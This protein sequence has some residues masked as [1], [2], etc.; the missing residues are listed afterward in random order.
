MKRR[1]VVKVGTKVL[2]DN[3]GVLDE[4]ALNRIVLQIAHLKLDGH[5]VTLV[6]SGAMGAGK[7]IF[8]TTKPLTGL[9][10]KQLYSAVGQAHL[11][12]TYSR[13]FAEHS[14]FCAQVLATKE[15]FRDRSHFFNM[16]NCLETLLHD[17]VVPIVNENDVVALGELAFTDNDELAGLVASMLNADLLLILSS[18]DGVNDFSG[19]VVGEITN[20]DYDMLSS[21]VTSDKSEAGRGGMATKFEVAKR[22]AK[23]GIEV[24]I[25]NGTKDNTVEAIVGGERLGTRFVPGKRLTHAQRRLA[26]SDALVMGR[27]YINECAVDIMNDDKVA[28]LLPVGAIKLEGDFEKGDVI[29]IR[30]PVGKLLGYGI[31]QYSASDAKVS[32]GKKNLKPLI[33]YDYMFIE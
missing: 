18:V 3:K 22:A 25:A 17:S 11:M 10:E 26:H 14:L 7:S 12:S 1:I 33:H 8:K 15:D 32:L 30:S 5:E 20:Q 29:E 16:R 2:T 28:S 9:S 6:S 23:E 31:S 19:E 24:I 13:L 27:V 21:F 4:R